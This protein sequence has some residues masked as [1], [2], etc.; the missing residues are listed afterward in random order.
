MTETSAGSDVVD[1]LP[2]FAS[3]TTDEDREKKA[4]R[5]SPGT[6]T[7]VVN[8][9]SFHY[10]PKYNDDPEVKREL[11]SPL[12]PGSTATSLPGSAGRESAMEWVAVPGGP[13]IVVLLRF[14][15][16][17]RRGTFSSEGPQSPI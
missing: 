1:D 3:L 5:S 2:P 4:E 11:L 8:Q 9:D 7:V 12:R 16:V 13:N 14:K 15:D 10:L 6:Y 17:V